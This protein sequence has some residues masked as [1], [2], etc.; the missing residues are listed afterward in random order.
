MPCG[1]TALAS[2]FP[3]STES[4]PLAAGTN[5]FVIYGQAQVGGADL[6]VP[7][8]LTVKSVGK[9]LIAVTDVYAY[10]WPAV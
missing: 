1:K 5:V 9:E 8:L 3:S 2:C 4:T 6:A 10:V 7:H